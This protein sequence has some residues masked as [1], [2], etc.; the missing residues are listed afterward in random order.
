[1]TE[2]SVH[3]SSKENILYGIY[4]QP[5]I[6]DDNRIGVLLCVAGLTYHV[7]LSRL[8]VRLARRL[9]KRGF[10][11]LRFD[12]HGIGDSD[13]TLQKRK[14]DDL[15]RDIEQGDF[16]EDTL[17]AFDYFFSIGH[18]DTVF[19]CGFCGGAVTAVLAAPKRL[20]QIKGVALAGPTALLHGGDKETSSQPITEESAR[21]LRIGYLRKILDIQAWVRLITLKTDI[22]QLIKSFIKPLLKNRRLKSVNEILQKVPNFN[23][24]FAQSYFTVTDK[25]IPILF[26][27]GERA[28]ERSEFDEI[29][30]PFVQNSDKNARASYD[31]RMVKDGDHN[32]VLPEA[33]ETVLNTLED[34]ISNARHR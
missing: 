22:R 33:Q 26:V 8:Y 30:F 2:K 12:P 17:A 9:T 14:V 20:P 24:A 19:L 34:W 3:F 27:F 29:F 7:G 6:E 15:F 25:K 11:V 21:Q 1:M 28:A 10:H 4:H 31:Y 18:I 16:V 5:N 13:G 32:F 23:T